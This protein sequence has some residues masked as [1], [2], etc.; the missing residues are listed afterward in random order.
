M[1]GGDGGMLEVR[2]IKVVLLVPNCTFD[3]LSLYFSISILC[4]YPN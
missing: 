4:S 1:E 3:L 2:V